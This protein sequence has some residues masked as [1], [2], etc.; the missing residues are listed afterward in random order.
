E[1]APF[2]PTPIGQFPINGT[3]TGAGFTLPA[4]K[5]TTITFKATLNNPPN[6]SGPTNPKVSAQGILTGTFIGNPIVTDDTT[7]GGTTDPT[8]TVVDLFDSTTT[9]GAVPSAG[10]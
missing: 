8:V 7:V 9:L 10:S 5:T 6:L 3:G 1:A 4:G 2:V